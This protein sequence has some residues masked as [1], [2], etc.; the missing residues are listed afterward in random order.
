MTKQS[1]AK[2]TDGR[3]FHP[4]ATYMKE[5]A[6]GDHLV[7]DT[8]YGAEPV[9]SVE[10]LEDQR[11]PG[12]LY[13]ETLIVIEVTRRLYDGSGGTYTARAIRSGREPATVWRQEDKLPDDIR[14]RLARIRDEIA[15]LTSPRCAA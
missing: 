12:F 1:Q 9:T 4:H 14:E 13:A 3:G 8:F 6:V 10:L 5:V 7:L 15:T 11:P 2:V